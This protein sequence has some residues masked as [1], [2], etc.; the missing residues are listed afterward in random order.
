MLQRHRARGEVG[1]EEP[2]PAVQLLEPRPRLRTQEHLRLGPAAQAPVGAVA[3]GERPCECAALGWAAGGWPPDPLAHQMTPLTMV[4]WSARM[5][6]ELSR[7]QGHWDLRT[8]SV[9]WFR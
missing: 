6:L 5:N 7:R 2:V 8:H 9:L 4:D 3:A 1:A